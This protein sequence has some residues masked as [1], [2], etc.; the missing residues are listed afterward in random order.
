MTEAD[1]ALRR[2]K[3]AAGVS[4]RKHPSYGK[5]RVYLCVCGST[6]IR[7]ICDMSDGKIPYPKPCD[8]CEY[9]LKLLPFTIEDSLMWTREFIKRTNGGTT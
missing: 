7:P 4:E 2:L 3:E 5:W 8:H 9:D 6:C 1:D